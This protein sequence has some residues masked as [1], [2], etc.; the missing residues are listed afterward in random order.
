MAESARE[1]QN[2]L[3]AAHE[4]CKNMKLA[5]NTSKTKIMIFSRGKVIKYPDFCF[6][7]SILEV[8]YEYL[9]LG[10]MFSYN[11][12]FNKAINKH[13]SQ[14]K[15]AMLAL[16]T[17]GRRLL[18]PLDVLFELFDKMILPILTYGIEIYS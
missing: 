12:S 17:K 18:L 9:Y 7:E 3:N 16:I 8:T 15:R 4:Y 5:V 10:I 2:A 1:L 11:G 13:I 6:G 14:T